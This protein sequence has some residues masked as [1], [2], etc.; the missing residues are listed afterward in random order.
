MAGSVCCNGMA[1]NV[2]KNSC[3]SQVRAGRVDKMKQKVN[4]EVPTVDIVVLQTENHILDGSPYN[5]NAM[6]M[7]KMTVN[8]DELDW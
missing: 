2:K 8:D 4:Y 5:S 3:D 7:E 1:G 6:R